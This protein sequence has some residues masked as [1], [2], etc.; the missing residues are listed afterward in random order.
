MKQAKKDYWFRAWSYGWG[1]VPV[2]WQGWT[3]I[4]VFILV[5]LVYVGIIDSISPSISDTVIIAAPSVVLLSLL[6]TFIC[7]KTGEHSGLQ[8]RRIRSK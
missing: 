5:V 8:W 2:T 6:L 7:Y 4:A 3:I 1:W